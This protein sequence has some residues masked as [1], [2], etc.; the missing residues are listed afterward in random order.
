MADPPFIVAEISKNWLNGFPLDGDP[1]LISEKLESVI[2]VNAA[3]GYRL[4]SFQLDRESGVDLHGG[5]WMNETIV[6]VF[7]K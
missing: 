5:A 1:A 7:A 2:N 4:H 3:R 6:A